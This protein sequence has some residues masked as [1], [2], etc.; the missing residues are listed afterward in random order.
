MDTKSNSKH[1]NNHSNTCYKGESINLKYDYGDVSY[2]LA[3]VYN[4]IKSNNNDGLK[5]LHLRT[6][7]SFIGKIIMNQ[8]DSSQMEDAMK[9]TVAGQSK[10]IRSKIIYK[11]K[12]GVNE[13]IF[14]P[15]PE[16]IKW[17][18]KVNKLKDISLVRLLD[19]FFISFPIQERIINK[20]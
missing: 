15:F 17:I 19:D 8:F 18:K 11:A 6:I 5:K 12:S 20:I 4:S 14:L 3:I 16:L 10:S 7:N 13:N 9:N 2:F 1:K